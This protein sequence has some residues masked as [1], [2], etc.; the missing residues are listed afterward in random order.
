MNGVGSMAC[1]AIDGTGARLPTAEAIINDDNDPMNFIPC[2][3]WMIFCGFQ[4]ARILRN[5]PILY[6][7]IK[8]SASRIFSGFITAR[9]HEQ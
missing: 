2:S 5:A 6:T 1:C 7:R 9:P 4:R 8:T 3:P